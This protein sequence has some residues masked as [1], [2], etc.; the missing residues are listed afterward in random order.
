MDQEK[1]PTEYSRVKGLV[2]SSIFADTATATVDSNNNYIVPFPN[3]VDYIKTVELC[4]GSVKTNSG[5]TNTTGGGSI[6]ASSLASGRISAYLT[7]GDLVAI[8]GIKGRIS[9]GIPS[10]GVVGDNSYMYMDSKG[11][12]GYYGDDDFPWFVVASTDMTYNGQNYHGGDFFVGNYSTAY[13]WWKY[14][15]QTLEIA[16]DILI[17]GDITS[18]NFAYDPVTGALTGYKLE[19]STENAYF[20][21]AIISGSSTIGTAGILANTIGSA[22]NTDGD[23]T[24]D[25]VNARLNTYTQKVLAGFTIS[26]DNTSASGFKAGTVT[27]DS[28]GNITG[29][30]GVAFTPYGIIGASAGTRKFAIDINGNAYFSG[31]ITGATGTFGSVTITTGSISWSALT[32]VP[33]P[34]G[35]QSAY[36]LYINASYMGYW[37]GSWQTYIKSDGT[38]FFGTSADKSVSWNG[39]TMSIRGSLNADDITAGTIT[40]RTLRTSSSGTRVEVDGSNNQINFYYSSSTCGYIKGS[41]IDGYACIYVSGYTHFYNYVTVSGDLNVISDLNVH[42]DIRAVGSITGTSLDING[43][44]DISS[45]CSI[46]GVLYMNYQNI[47]DVADPVNNQDAANKQW[48]ESH[49]API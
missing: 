17:A 2:S 36:G 27:W 5:S 48:C 49:F 41:T 31:D 39:T 45:Y 38:F 26:A 23:L 22:I 24:N 3:K 37:N 21:G 46:H 35:S 20:G 16:G 47:R 4:N 33:T 14:A 6:S 12:F 42:S 11:I 19:Y 8:D 7:V 34:L 43:Y 15:S 30:T 13:L 29:G 25:V 28:S 32:S 44:A 18:T 40:G 10:T 1:F 9:F